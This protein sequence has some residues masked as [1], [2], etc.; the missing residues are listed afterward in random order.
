MCIATPVEG[1]RSFSSFG[2]EFLV[3]LVLEVMS[4]RINSHKRKRDRN[5][6]KQHIIIYGYI[7]KYSDNDLPLDIMG[8]CVSYFS[9][10]PDEWDPI[11]INVYVKLKGKS[12]INKG[13]SKTTSFCKRIVECGHHEWKFKIKNISGEMIFGIWKVYQTA[14]PAFISGENFMYTRSGNYGFSARNGKISESYGYYDGYK[15]KQYAKKC[16]KGAIIEMILDF[17]QLTLNFKINGKDYGVSHYIQ[18]GQYRAAVYMC[19]E[20]DRVDLLRH[21]DY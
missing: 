16:E 12:I 1:M 9:G 13:L 21:F 6:I 20:G 2:G 15:Y 11:W 4:R 3:V 17:N 8:I 18:K 7:R 14:I 19:L 10:D 5:K